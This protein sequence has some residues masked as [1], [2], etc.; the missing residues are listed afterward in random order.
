MDDPQPEPSRCSYEDFGVRFVETA[1]TAERI[2]DAIALITGD[3]V[4]IGPMRAGPGGI[5]VVDATGR[6]GT[7]TA[8]LIPDPLVSYLVRIPVALD[9]D[10]A[11]S[12]QHHRY[13]AALLVPIVV[14]AQTADPLCIVIDVV[15]PRARDIAIT[16]TADGLQARVLQRLGNVETQIRIQVREFIGRMVAGDTARQ[17][18]TIDVAELIT[19]AWRPGLLT[20]A[21]A[22]QPEIT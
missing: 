20:G 17:A 9:V 13:Q 15:R 1:V 8:E 22:P 19:R 11:L 2:A 18:M 5:A 3:S 10:I 12:N 21:P 4:S 6:L 16:L 7:I 14:K